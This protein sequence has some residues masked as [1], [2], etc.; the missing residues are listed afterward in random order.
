MIQAVMSAIYKHINSNKGQMLIEVLIALGIVVL[1]LVALLSAAIVSVRNSR[2][3]QS[4]VS[5]NQYTQEGIEKARQVRD[6]AFSW[7]DFTSSYSGPKGLNSSLNWDV[8]CP[9]P[10]NP[11]LGIF[12]RCVDFDN[13]DI[14]GEL[15]TVTVTVSWTEGS[16]LYSS[17]AVTILSKWN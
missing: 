4:I 16:R 13:S 10:D 6:Q 9:T 1:V 11:N 8:V 3:S 5:A 14:S 2:F 12:T 15:S 17:Q 7:S